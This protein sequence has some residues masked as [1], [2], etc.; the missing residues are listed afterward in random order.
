MDYRKAAPK[1]GRQPNLFSDSL[2]NNMIDAPIKRDGSRYKY[3][4]PHYFPIQS[5]IP[6]KSGIVMR[7]GL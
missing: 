4:Q 6:E 3:R 2:S 7:S 5:R 1:A